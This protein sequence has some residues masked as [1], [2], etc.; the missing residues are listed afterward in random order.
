[1]SSFSLP[2]PGFIFACLYVLALASLAFLNKRD[3]ERNPEKRKRYIALPLPY[4]FGCWFVVV[5]MFVG[6]VL[7]P[8]LFLAAIVAFLLL[9]AACIRWY[10][11]A[12][13]Y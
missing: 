5:P 9:E 2:H 4:K 11:R 8:W 3:F 7:V 10:R 12:G 1:M 13:L 6:A